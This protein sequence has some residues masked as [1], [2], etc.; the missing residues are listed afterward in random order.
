M[1]LLDIQKKLSP[2]LREYGI[3]KAAVFGSVSRGDDRPDSDV[4]ILISLG[5]KPMG[6]LAFVS[7]TRQAE[8]QLGRKVDIVTENGINKFIRPFITQDLKTIYEG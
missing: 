3:K 6:M 4:D 1:S 2:L 5:E 7:M 8:E